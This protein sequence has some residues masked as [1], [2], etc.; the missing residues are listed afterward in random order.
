MKKVEPLSEAI[1]FFTNESPKWWV[2]YLKVGF[3]HCFV[4]LRSG[5]DWIIYDPLLKSTTFCVIPNYTASMLKEHFKQLG[6]L[7]IEV[8]VRNTTNNRMYLATTCVT[9][10]ALAIG[11]PSKPWWTPYKLY[12]EIIKM[13]GK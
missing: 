12:K 8:D 6:C 9:R 13:K 10:V 2:Q 7:N 11:I 4:A 5:N 1:V 3:R